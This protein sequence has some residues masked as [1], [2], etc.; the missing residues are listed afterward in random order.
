MT[1]HY[2]LHSGVMALLSPWGKGIGMAHE[3]TVGLERWQVI[4]RVSCVLVAAAVA[5]ATSWLFSWILG[6]YIGAES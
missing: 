6:I 2:S 5:V 4:H 1:K 3:P